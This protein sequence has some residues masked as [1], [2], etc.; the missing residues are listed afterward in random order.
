MAVGAGIGFGARRVGK[1]FGAGADDV[2]TAG[3][4]SPPDPNRPIRRVLLTPPK[5]MDEVQSWMMEL[6]GN[7]DPVDVA[8]IL[9]MQYKPSA[10]TQKNA[11]GER[12]R[13]RIEQERIEALQLVYKRSRELKPP[14][15]FAAIKAEARAA[16][17]AQQ[18]SADVL[19][20][21]REPPPIIGNGLGGGGPRK[22][23]APKPDSPDAIKNALRDIIKEGDKQPTRLEQM[24]DAGK[25]AS[26]PPAKP[27]VAEEDK[28]AD[29]ATRMLERGDDVFKIHDKTGVVMIPYNN[30]NV[31]LYAP[32]TNPERAIRMF[33]E[34]LS[35]PP[36]DRPEWVRGALSQAKRKSG[37]LLTNRNIAPPEMVPQPPANALAN[38]PPERFPVGAVIGGA[39][40]GA[41]T[42][43]AGGVAA[44]GGYQAFKDEQRKRNALAQ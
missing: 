42:G 16:E 17:A 25:D 23:R 37:L 43:I 8:Q 24:V 27:G 11:V 29:Q 9:G 14:P 38:L 12:I 1:A 30:S 33:Y 40:G 10:I 4:G 5:D 2:A 44:I 36:K 19:P 13:A 18:P 22:P 31:P 21:T 7:Q 34:A 41:A 39:L 26:V 28:L 15:D 35:L 6:Q 32:D 3:K 20:F